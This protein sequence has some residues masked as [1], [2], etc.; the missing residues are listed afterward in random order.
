MKLSP[1]ERPEAVFI[2]EAGKNIYNS[3]VSNIALTTFEE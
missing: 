1:S 3:S 2:I